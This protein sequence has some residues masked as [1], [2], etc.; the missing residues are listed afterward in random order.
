MEAEDSFGGCAS[1]GPIC[2]HA[3]FGPLVTTESLQATVL[4][5]NLSLRAVETCMAQ[6]TKATAALSGGCAVHLDATWCTADAKSRSPRH[7]PPQQAQLPA[8]TSIHLHA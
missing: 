5:L 8:A 4:V 1:F 2:I 7:H 3:T 6:D